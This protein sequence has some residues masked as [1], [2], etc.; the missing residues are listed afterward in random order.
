MIDPTV[1][2]FFT[3][4][5]DEYETLYRLDHGPRIAELLRRYDLVNQLK[6]KR[7][8][9]VGGGQGFLGEMLDSSTE[10]WVIDGAEIPLNKRLCKGSWVQ[11]DLDYDRFADVPYYQQD[12][13]YGYSG[14]RWPQF[15]MGFA[16]EVLEHLSNPY[17][18]LEQMKKLIKPDGLIHISLPCESVWHNV[19]YPSLIWPPQ[20]WI[21]FLQ[22]MALPV[23]DHWTYEP[24][25]RGWPA[26]QYVCINKP[27][28]EKRLIYPKDDPKFL[29]ATPLQCTNL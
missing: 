19:V 23:L 27:W 25:E 4:G 28:S 2:Q 12:T 10:Y 11:R 13:S 16:L 18:A 26:Y 17:Q 29:H 6:Y 1:S 9:D 24:K 20:N 21:V 3:K 14:G 8:V 7:V 15:D 22:Q 5:G